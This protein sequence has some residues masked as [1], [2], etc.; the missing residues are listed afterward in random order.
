MYKMNQMDSG[1]GYRNPTPQPW[2]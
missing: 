2:F 1:V